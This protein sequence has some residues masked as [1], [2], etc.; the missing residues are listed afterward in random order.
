MSAGKVVQAL[1]VTRGIT[2]FACQVRPIAGKLLQS[3]SAACGSS[4]GSSHLKYWSCKNGRSITSGVIGDYRSEVSEEVREPS[5]SL[6]SRTQ[7]SSDIFVI[8]IL[9]LGLGLTAY[10]LTIRGSR[11]QTAACVYSVEFVLKIR[12]VSLPLQDDV[13]E[14]PSD[15]LDLVGFLGE[16]VQAVKEL[17][18]PHGRK[19]LPR[20]ASTRGLGCSFSKQLGVQD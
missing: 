12:R 5:P 6:R 19:R 9:F 13:P 7:I 2:R 20:Q 11:E 8:L 4:I 18:S 16:R 15:A 17:L 1:K 10:L 3:V 14:A